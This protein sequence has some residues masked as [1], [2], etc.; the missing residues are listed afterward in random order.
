MSLHL[1]SGTTTEPTIA[2]VATTTNEQLSDEIDGLAKQYGV[3]A[4][5]AQDIIKCESQD[6]PDALRKNYTNGSLT[7]EDKSYWQINDRYWQVPLQKMGWD[8]N[9]PQQNLEAGFYLLSKYGTKLWSWSKPCWG[10]LTKQD[11]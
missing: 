3:N 8:I 1:I 6:K 2:E 9:N 11:S 10:R 5:V 4:T 7:S